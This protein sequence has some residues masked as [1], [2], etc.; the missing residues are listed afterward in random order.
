[1]KNEIPD[2]LAYASFDDDRDILKDV[3]VTVGVL[4]AGL[5][6]WI[7]VGVGIGYLIWG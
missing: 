3:C 7:G 4:V 2:V 1:M 5:G 6:F